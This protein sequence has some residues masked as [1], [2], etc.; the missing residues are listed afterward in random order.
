IMKFAS[1]RL[2]TVAVALAAPLG[3]QQAPFAGGG[4]KPMTSEEAL[5]VVTK[6][7]ASLTPLEK[8]FNAAQAKLKKSPKDAKVKTAYVDA[9]YKYGHA[10]M[11]DRGKLPP[12]IQYRA[13]LALYRKA[14]AVDPKHKPSLEDKKLIEDIYKQ[15]GMPIPQ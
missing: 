4:G 1:L 6:T 15:M 7:D 14:L 12:R 2:A 10:V 11:M 8:G 3:A 5:K 9:T 13:A